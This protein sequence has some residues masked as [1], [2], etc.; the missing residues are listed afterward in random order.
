MDSSR[1]LLMFLSFILFAM[2]IIMIPQTLAQSG[3]PA[4]LYYFC[5][6][7]KGNYTANSTY[8]ENLKTLL[9]SLPS[10]NGNGYGFYNSSQGSESS[11]DQVYAIGLCRGDVS[12]D[13][14]R[15][16][17]NNSTHALPQLCPNQREAIG[18][19]DYCMFRY[20][21]RSIYGIT[22]TMPAFYYWNPYNVSS[23]SLDGFNQELR[24]LLDSLKSEAASGGSFRKFAIGN[25]S[26]SG[27][28]TIYALVQCTP[29]LSELECNNCLDSCFGDIPTCCDGKMG[30]RVVRPSCNVR[31]EAYRFFDDRTVVPLPSPPLSLPIPPQPSTN[32]STGICIC[33]SYFLI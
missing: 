30:G 18:W 21:N 28:I 12:L 9:S 11:E 29:D 32:T 26:A 13:D 2:I 31:F 3:Y 6:N 7:D 33:P 27:F 16:C 22:E 15:S 17:L 10:S 23:S 24:K 19:Y 14:C 4:F 25:A 8:Q 1:F 5:I 20:S